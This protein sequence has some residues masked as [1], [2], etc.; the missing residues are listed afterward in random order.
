MAFMRESHPL[1]CDL[2]VIGTLGS[3]TV[4]TWRGIRNL[5]R[6][7][8]PRGGDLYDEPHR[9]K[10]LV[11]CSAKIGEFCASIVAGRR[12]GRARKRA[13]VRWLSSWP[14]IERPATREL[15]NWEN[16]CRLTCR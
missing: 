14:F 3:V 6:V 9:A 5:E 8:P 10:V 7:R 15:W 4:H 12:P 16:R 11:A 13:L 2:Q 1:V